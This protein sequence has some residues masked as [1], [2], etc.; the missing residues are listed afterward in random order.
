MIRNCVVCGFRGKEAEAPDGLCP[1]C[2][3][4]LGLDL[5]VEPIDEELQAIEEEASEDA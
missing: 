4:T 5:K 2:G 1:R 3:A